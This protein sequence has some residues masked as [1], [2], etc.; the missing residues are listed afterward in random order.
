MDGQRGVVGLHHH[1]GHLGRRHDGKR[2]HDPVRIFL[3]DLGDEERP[4]AGPGPA[5]ERVVQLESLQVNSMIRGT[6][7]G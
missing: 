2:A 1:V 4:H 6:L 5:P 7:N 3:P